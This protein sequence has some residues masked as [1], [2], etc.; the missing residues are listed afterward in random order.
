MEP[1]T[2]MKLMENEIPI[3]VEFVVYEIHF[4]NKR[5]EMY[6]CSYAPSPLFYPFLVRRISWWKGTPKKM[7]HVYTFEVQNKQKD[8]SENKQGKR[9]ELG[10]GKCYVL[11]R[12]SSREISRYSKRT[13]KYIPP[14]L[15]REF[16]SNL[17]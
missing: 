9:E 14:L 10:S 7:A 11:L 1:S 17:I 8:F 12:N 6:F 15:Q 2:T 16:V 13:K 3:G 5:D 4:S